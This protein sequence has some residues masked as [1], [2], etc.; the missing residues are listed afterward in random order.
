MLASCTKQLCLSRRKGLRSRRPAT[1]PGP[2]H[3]HWPRPAQ[4]GEPYDR[5]QFNLV[6]RRGNPH[7]QA[8]SPQFTARGSRQHFSTAPSSS[9]QHIPVL[10]ALVPVQG[11]VKK[12]EGNG[13][14]STSGNVILLRCSVA[15]ACCR[16]GSLVGPPSCSQA[17]FLKKYT[18][19]PH[20]GNR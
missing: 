16:P 2:R 17:S 1:L 20:A 10:L 5:H 4:P 3:R 7:P 12:F 11:S 9:R 14:P 19:V 13:C 15:P 6:G 8:L 18:R